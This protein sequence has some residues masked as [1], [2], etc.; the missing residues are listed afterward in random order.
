VFDAYRASKALEGHLRDGDRLRL[1]ALDDVSGDYW[2]VTDHELIVISNGEI[3]ARFPLEPIS[4]AVSST[5]TG[6]EVRVRSAAKPDT[7][8]ASFRRPNKVTDRLSSLLAPKPDAD[9]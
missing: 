8:I 9:G 3:T 7:S 1:V 2:V 5:A 6:V 4:G